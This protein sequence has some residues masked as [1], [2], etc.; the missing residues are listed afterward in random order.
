MPK[1]TKKQYF[2]SHQNWM[3]CF[4][5]MLCR[6]LLY[7]GSIMNQFI[8]NL[9][10]LGWVWITVNWNR[11]AACFIS[12]HGLEPVLRS[13]KGMKPG[14]WEAACHLFI[15]FSILWVSAKLHVMLTVSSVVQT[16][17]PGRRLCTSGKGA[18]WRSGTFAP[19]G[20]T[21]SPSWAWGT[22]RRSS[23]PSQVGERALILFF[24]VLYKNVCVRKE[25]SWTSWGVC[26]I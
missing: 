6:S 25:I 4:V 2:F 15:S 13:T 26:M 9:A 1:Q 21:S 14:L 11:A 12:N 8:C 5:N 24:F 18:Q 16:A 10:H 22:P 17:T 20:S 19:G 7:N 23:G 3:R